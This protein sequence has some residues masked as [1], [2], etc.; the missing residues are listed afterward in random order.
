MHQWYH[1]WST[2]IQTIY[3][4]YAKQIWLQSLGSIY[5]TGLLLHGIWLVVSHLI[6]CG[7]NKS[8][9]WGNVLSCSLYKKFQCQ[10]FP[11]FWYFFYIINTCAIIKTRVERNSYIFPSIK[12]MKKVAICT[13]W[14]V[15]DSK[16]KI[17]AIM[18]G[19]TTLQLLYSPM[20]LVYV[21][22][23]TCNSS[24]LQERT[25]LFL[26]HIFPRM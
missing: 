18:Y 10:L 5:K 2:W 7:N 16:T 8:S 9:V 13:Y 4:R 24:Q 6:C 23:A 12:F 19:I 21:Q 26:N 25:S 22:L 14:S 1:I 17:T 15:T 3:R 20:N 11:L